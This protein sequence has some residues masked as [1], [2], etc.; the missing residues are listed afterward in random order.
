MAL[1]AHTQLPRSPLFAQAQAPLALGE[2]IL[3]GTVYHQF[4]VRFFFYFLFYSFFSLRLFSL[5]VCALLLVCYAPDDPVFCDPLSSF[6]YLTRTW[7]QREVPL[8]FAYLGLL[9]KWVPLPSF[10][11]GN[12]ERGKWGGEGIKEEEGTEGE[13]GSR[14]SSVFASENQ[15]KFDLIMICFDSRRCRQL[16]WERSRHEGLRSAGRNESDGWA[17]GAS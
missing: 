12:I 5:L 14:S 3:F 4:Y 6:S 10:K 1:C 9:G 15:L 8:L 17:S 2:K 16:E 7:L 13:E 11:G